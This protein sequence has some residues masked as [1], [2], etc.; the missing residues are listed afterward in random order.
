[1]HDP[2]SDLDRPATWLSAVAATDPG[3]PALAFADRIVTYGALDGL[4]ARAAAALRKR[5]AGAGS[6]IGVVIGEPTV[7]SIATLW[8]AWRLGAAAMPLDPARSAI[9]AVDDVVDVL[10]LSEETWTG[11]TP[12]SASDLHSLVLT[13]GSEAGPRACRITHGNVA[14]AVGASAQRL[15]NGAGDRWLLALPLFH[16][17][18]VSIL[19]RS[20]AAGGC[21]VVQP[22]FDAEDA[23]VRLRSG[24]VT[25]ASL[26][27]TMLRRIL[28]VDAGPYRGVRAV[29]L[30]GAA[31]PHSLVERGLDAG[32]P[33]LTTYGMTETC[34][35]VATVVPGRE[36]ESL[37][38]VGEPLEGMVVT[39]VDGKVA[40][41]GPAVSPGYDG[42]PSRQGPL[43]T[44]D[45]GFFDDAGRLVVTGR[46]DDV[47]ITGG[48]N[49]HPA[50]VE[51]VLATHPDV[52]EVAVVGSPDAEWGERVTA[53]IVARPGLSGED[54]AAH[55]RSGLT[56]AQ[57]PRE[58]R[59]VPSIPLLRNGKPDRGAIR[60]MIRERGDDEAV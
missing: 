44:N 46:A 6:R 11:D 25:I 51:A 29:L 31:A 19:W 2:R 26:V 9:H 22:R 28:D 58:W 48:V 33:I 32:L 49:V 8:G 34:S 4:A 41:D 60:R 15:R 23:A 20:A 56:G 5:G 53:V 13:S 57:V 35:Q 12:A 55:A 36:R 38:T 43:V 3:S 47:I 37:G 18:G 50:A 54:L 7:E 21:V 52:V 39:V 30:G 59:M 14:A 16:I 17:G 27:P 45:L 10:D 40:V 42:E 24:D 1:M